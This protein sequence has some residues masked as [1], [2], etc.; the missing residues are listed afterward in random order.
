MVERL[1]VIIPETEVK[2]HQEAL[3]AA[4]RDDQG[5]EW[6]EQQVIL[7]RKKNFFGHF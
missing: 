3:R 6:W 1:N 4:I 5:A 7:K 2:V